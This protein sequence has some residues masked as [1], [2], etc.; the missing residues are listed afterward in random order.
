MHGNGVV[1]RRQMDVLQRRRRWRLTPVAAALSGWPAR[2]DHLR[3]WRGIRR[4]RRVRRRSLVTAVGQQRSAIWIHDDK[5]E[6]QVTTEGVAS[7]PLFSLDARRLYY[8]LAERRRLHTFE[9]RSMEL[10]SGRTDRLIT[11][12]SVEQFDVSPDER[13]VAFSTLTPDGVSEIWLADDRSTPPRRIVQSAD[14]VWF[15]SDT[16]LIFRSLDSPANTLQRIR[17]DGSERQRLLQHANPLSDWRVPKRRGPSSSSPRTTVARRLPRG[18]CRYAGGVPAPFCA[19]CFGIW[20]PNGRWMYLSI[21]GGQTMMTDR[22]LAV[23]TGAKEAPPDRVAEMLKAAS[24]G[25]PPAGTHLIDQRSFQIGPSN[26]PTSYAFVRRDVQRNLFEIPR[27]PVRRIHDC[28]SPPN[29]GWSDWGAWRI[30]TCRWHL[31]G[32][33]PAPAIQGAHG[34]DIVSA[35]R[36]RSSTTQ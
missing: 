33:V 24:A 29:A 19:G 6:R 22:Y 36:P 13:E 31:A 3:T 21:G 17:T 23:P 7:S 15:G 20:S 1:T 27:H 18:L 28:S 8:L 14:Q 10:S 35:C 34:V 9:L 16:E 32:R 11:D 12:R 30:S 5:G 2:A 26:D 4:Q 25:H